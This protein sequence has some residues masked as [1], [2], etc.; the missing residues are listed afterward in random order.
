MTIIFKK[1]GLKVSYILICGSGQP[2]YRGSRT[3]TRQLEG[4]MK[5]HAS[6]VPQKGVKQANAEASC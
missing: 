6:T 2:Y 4:S 3:H 5:T 1:P